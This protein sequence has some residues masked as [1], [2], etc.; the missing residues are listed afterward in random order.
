MNEGDEDRGHD[1]AIRLLRNLLRYPK[2]LPRV[3][4]TPAG[5]GVSVV[6]REKS[7]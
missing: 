1:P 5:S 3:D 4:P 6:A 7:R 2:S